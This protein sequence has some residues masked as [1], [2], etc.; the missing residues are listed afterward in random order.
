MRFF[1]KKLFI[2]LLFL[3]IRAPK[4]GAWGTCPL[5]PLDTPLAVRKNK[6]LFFVWLTRYSSA[7]LTPL[8]QINVDLKEHKWKMLLKKFHGSVE[9]FLSL[10]LPILSIG[11]DFAK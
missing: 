10:F 5:A 2:F 9:N 7:G 8:E 3:K 1:G 4:C 6:A 11:K